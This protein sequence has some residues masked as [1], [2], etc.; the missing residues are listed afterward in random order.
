MTTNPE[1]R[2]SS[3]Q[4]HA[5]GWQSSPGGGGVSLAAAGFGLVVILTAIMALT[6]PM[7]SSSQVDPGRISIMG[8]SAG[9]TLAMPAASSAGGTLSMAKLHG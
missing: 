6:P 2:L 4:Q 3:I 9:S 1:R 8:G 7:Q 5:G